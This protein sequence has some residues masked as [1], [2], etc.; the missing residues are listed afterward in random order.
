MIG[1]KNPDHSER[2]TGES[3]PMYG[4]SGELSPTYGLT[5][6]KSPRYGKKQWINAKGE[7]KF[8]PECPGPEWQNGLRWREVR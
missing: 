3:N 8:C 2:M 5:G 4:K 6:E 7:K 1:R